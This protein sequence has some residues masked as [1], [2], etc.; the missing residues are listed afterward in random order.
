MPRA[1]VRVF[2]SSTWK[3]LQPERKAVEELIHQL[4]TTQYAGMEYFGSQPE[5]TTLGSLN[6]IESCDLYI[7]II[8]G[9]Y[10]SG[11]TEA[12]YD[13]A[14]QLGLPCL[15]YFNLKTAVRRAHR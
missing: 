13:R 12:E 9:R 8:S 11:I 4:R 7:G 6:E 5:D 3:D 14:F 15:I 10:G 2:V 1:P